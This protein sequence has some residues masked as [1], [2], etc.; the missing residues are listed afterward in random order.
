MTRSLTTVSKFLSYVLR[1]QPEPIGLTL[2]QEG[3]ANI[4][5][6]ISKANIPIDMN[7]LREV[8]ATS[9]KKRFAISDDGMFIRAN[10]GH[11]VSVNLGLKSQEPPEFLYHGTATHSLKSIKEEGL[12]PQ[13]R[14]YVHLSVDKHTAINVGRRHGDPVVVVIPALKMHRNGHQFIQAHNG[15]WLTKYVPGRSILLL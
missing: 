11:S 14:Q 1:H 12:L 4:Q 6:L 2:D 3:W 8:T 10:Q 7:V 15:V 13:A 9:D 5:E